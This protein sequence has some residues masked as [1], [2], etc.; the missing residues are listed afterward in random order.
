MLFEVESLHLC[1]QETER[2]CGFETS[3]PVSSDAPAPTRPH[4]LDHSSITI[5]WRPAIQT[6][7]SVGEARSY[8]NHHNLWFWISTPSQI[9]KIPKGCTWAAQ[10]SASLP[11]FQICLWM[12]SPYLESGKGRKFSWYYVVRGFGFFPIAVCFLCLLPV[13]S[14]GIFLGASLL[15]KSWLLQDSLSRLQL[16]V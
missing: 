3:K 9:L 10:L 8:L 5:S 4:L 6:S 7:K 1:L 2:A 15:S 14:C 11:L 13:L 16:W 12:L